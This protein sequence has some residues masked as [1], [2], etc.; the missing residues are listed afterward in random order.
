[1]EQ[2]NRLIILITIVPN[3]DDML[4]NVFLK[5]KFEV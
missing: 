5:Y 1:M 3:S 4:L 2:E